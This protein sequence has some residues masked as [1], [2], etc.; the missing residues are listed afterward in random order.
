MLTTE[1]ST[2]FL[3]DKEEES[4][5]STKNIS[6]IGTSMS[7]RE[8]KRSWTWQYFVINDAHTHAICGVIKHNGF[9]CGA[10]IA[11]DKSGSTK[12]LHVHL[13]RIHHLLD[14]AKKDKKNA[15]IKKL[16]QTETLIAKVNIGV[17]NI[18]ISILLTYIFYRTH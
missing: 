9:K 11:L 10:H 8:G 5:A 17:I 1:S 6:N 14:P 15:S 4:I 2:S 16:L 7:T 13:M 18:I 12:N 3:H